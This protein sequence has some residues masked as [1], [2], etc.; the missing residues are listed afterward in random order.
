VGLVAPFG[1]AL[2]IGFGFL[3]VLELWSRRQLPAEQWR[4]GVA[5]C[6]TLMAAGAV[7]LLWRLV[8]LAA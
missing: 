5:I 6:G 2:F 4:R 7:L 3:L 1:W 8:D